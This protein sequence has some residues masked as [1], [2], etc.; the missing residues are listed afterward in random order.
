MLITSA[1]LVV[2][3]LVAELI[4]A[5]KPNA[6]IEP[7]LSFDNATCHTQ[8]LQWSNFNDEPGGPRI[9]NRAI[10]TLQVGFRA[11]QIFSPDDVLLLERLS[12]P[13]D[14]PE[15]FFK[16]QRHKE[17]LPVIP[18]AFVNELTYYGNLAA[19]AYCKEAKLMTWKCGRRCEC[20]LTSYLMYKI[21][22]VDTPWI[23]SVSYFRN[24]QSKIAG[25]VA[26]N[27]ILKEIYVSFRGTKSFVNWIYNLYSSKE[28]VPWRHGSQTT[29]VPKVHQ[30]FLMAYNSVKKKVSSRIR[31]LILAHPTYSIRVVGHSLGGALATLCAMELNES[32]DFS[33]KVRLVTFGAPRVGNDAFINLVRIHFPEPRDRIRVTNGQDV[34]P[35]LPPFLMGYRH[36]P[37]EIYTPPGAKDGTVSFACD[38]FSGEDPRCSNARVAHSVDDHL[39]FPH[40]VDFGTPCES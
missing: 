15:H 18:T 33:T 39:Y 6:T 35:H 34:V 16:E 22:L 29:R 27:D 11:R 26:A 9:T 23:T 8:K 28:P 21:I 5:D 24:G 3:N 19:A 7:K 20:I 32:L 12:V 2:F 37:Q 36:A 25:F 13:P 40:G 31:T 4:L 38:P 1:A 17:S 14:R 10:K 30:G